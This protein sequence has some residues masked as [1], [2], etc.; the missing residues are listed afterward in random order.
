[1][2]TAIRRITT[3]ESQVLLLKNK[4]NENDCLSNPCQNGGTCTDIFDGFI[5]K[6]TPNW[7]GARCNEDVNEC[8]DF[9]GSDLG[10]QNGATCMNTIGAY[11]YVI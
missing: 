9:V 10:C 5:C 3:L 11:R 8:L 2:R 6:C 1:M 4:L 7:T